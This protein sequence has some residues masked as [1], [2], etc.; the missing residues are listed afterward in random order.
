MKNRSV[1]VLGLG[2]SGVA[3][4]QLS[5]YLGSK[6]FI[7][8]KSIT[9]SVKENLKSLES[10]GIQGEAGSHSDK[11]FNTD[12]MVISPGVAADSQVVLEAQK[13][14]IKVIGEIEFASLF[15]NS[16]II[17]V[18]GSNGKST[19]V[20]ALAE[21]CQTDEVNGVL[22]GNVG[23]AFSS[24]VLEELQ[25]PDLKRVYILEISSFQMEF[26]EQFHPHISIFLN[27]SSDH[28]DRH[29][30]FKNYTNAK[31]RLSENQTKQDSVIYNADDKILVEVLNKHIAN[32]ITFSPKYSEANIYYVKNSNIINK[33][34]AKLTHLKNIGLPGQHNI[35]NL[36]A[37]ASG[38]HCL[39][40]SDEIIAHVLQSFKGIPHRLE[41]ITEINGIEFIN[42]SKATNIDAVKVAI[43][44]Y[45]KPI[46]LIL[47]GL[48]KG[49]DFAELL[50]F[51]NKIKNI[52]AYGTAKEMI[53]KELS[54]AFTVSKIELL[55]DAV[56]LSFQKAEKG[57]IVLLSPGC[58]SFDQFNNF[59]DRG[60]KFAQWVRELEK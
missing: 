10:V 1:F 12:L 6:V 37:A 42:D 13:R 48:A 14:G 45:E 17:G 16:S 33:E 27:I 40:I 56:K 20:H 50:Q 21:M 31:L 2:R 60:N 49:N 34:Y 25:I 46:I 39:G 3:I 19:T 18:T 43:E 15:T 47:G 57:E 59:E 36:L 26:I 22:A 41:S 4:A 8:D 7:S 29:K 52:I 32:K 28:L 23:L 9:N 55:K 51:K 38:A 5:N 58:A 54:T 11:I 44:S 53:Q 24:K 30:T 35:Y